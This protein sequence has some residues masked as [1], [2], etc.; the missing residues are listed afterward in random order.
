VKTPI[1]VAHDLA[2]KFSQSKYPEKLFVYSAYGIVY[3]EIRHPSVLPP[4]V[5]PTLS[6]YDKLAS[7]PSIINIEVSPKWQRRGL[8]RNIVNALCQLDVVRIVVVD[9]VFNASFKD[10][11]M[12]N[13]SWRLLRSPSLPVE[14]CFENSFYTTCGR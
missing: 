2:L 3:V 12:N 14:L 6:I 8:F 11:L 5:D 10:Y 1:S 7:C 9:N 13:E 4:N